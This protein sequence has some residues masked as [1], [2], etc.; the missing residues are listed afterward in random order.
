LSRLI[1]QMFATAAHL[2]TGR[3]L[4]SIKMNADVVC[5][6]KSPTRNPCAHKSNKRSA[7]RHNT[8]RVLI[9]NLPVQNHTVCKHR[10]PFIR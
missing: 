5:K 10:S 1:V 9:L 3:L 2:D 8:E 4:H 6:Q 7:K